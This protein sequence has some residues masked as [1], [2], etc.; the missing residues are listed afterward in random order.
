MRITKHIVSG[1]AA[2]LGLCLV[3]SG[4]NFAKTGAVAA[5]APDIVTVLPS[6]SGFTSVTVPSGTAQAL[7]SLGVSISPSGSATQ[8]GSVVNFP[9]TSGYLEVHSRH[10]VKPGWIDGSLDHDGSGIDL[11]GIGASV[12]LSDFVVDPGNSM[13]YATVNGTVGVPFLSLDGSKVTAAVPNNNIT[14]SDA[15]NNQ[16]VLNGTVAKLTQTAATAIDKAFSTTTITAGTPLG[17]VEVAASGEPVTYNASEDPVTAI[18][19]LTGMSTTLTEEPGVSSALTSAGLALTP[20]GAATSPKPGAVTFPITG[21]FVA[22]HHNRDFSPGYVVG[23]IIHQTSGV[24]IG[25]ATAAPGGAKPVALSDFVVDP[26]DSVLT[27][28]VNGKI[29]VPLFF[30]DGAKLTITHT[31]GG[32]ILD[33]TVAE[34]T[35][36]AATALDQAFNTKLFTAGMAIGTVHLVATGS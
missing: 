5:D 35:G 20:S 30:L 26:G 34:L 14:T 21:G 17:T 3:A 2:T 1:L 16:I 25:P 9:I 32:V 27:G 10:D 36:D 4:C 33:G 19:R 31:A 13:L 8:Q 11:R 18:S 15:D 22:I 28:T 6:V 29:D 23:S 24:T 7:T 12:S